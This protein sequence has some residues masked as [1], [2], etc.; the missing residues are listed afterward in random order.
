MTKEGGAVAVALVNAP[1][2]SR[3]VVVTKTRRNSKNLCGQPA[4]LAL[5]FVCERGQR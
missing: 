3:V 1:F 2:G 4:V 5:K